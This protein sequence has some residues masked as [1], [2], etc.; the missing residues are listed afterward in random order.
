MTSANA[1]K[2]IRAV[3][4]QI[5]TASSRNGWH[6]V[7]GVKHAVAVCMASR[8]A[9]AGAFWARVEPTGAVDGTSGAGAAQQRHTGAERAGRALHG[10]VDVGRAASAPLMVFGAHHAR[11]ATPAGALARSVLAIQLAFA[12][13][14]VL[15][16]AW[17]A[18]P[19]PSQPTYCWLEAAVELLLLLVRHLFWRAVAT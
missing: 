17:V 13:V 19:R 9:A 14:Y 2:A 3:R 8:C 4:W 6:V 15:H 11:A 7:A 16:A 1:S 18:F 10:R 5:Q 12:V